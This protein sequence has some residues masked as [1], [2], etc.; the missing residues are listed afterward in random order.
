MKKVTATHIKPF[1]SYNPYFILPFAV[2]VV[3]GGISLLLFDKQQLFSL[4]NVHHSTVGDMLMENI[5]LLGEGVFSTILLLVLMGTKQ[6]RNWWYFLSAVLTNLVPVAVTQYVKHAVDAPRPLKYFNEAPWIHT[7]PEWPRL[8]EHSFPSGHTSAAFCLF[9]FI[10]LLLPPRFRWLGII[11]FLLAL[12]VGYSRMY[13]AAHFFLDVY[14]GS[15]IGATFT[16]GIMAVMNRL[17]GRFFTDTIADAS[18]K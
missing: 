15:I 10:A 17:S 5:T 3:T 4:F 12:A 8:M 7:L 13:L 9:T 6:L 1:T 18:E 11:L 16:I 2:W 14:V